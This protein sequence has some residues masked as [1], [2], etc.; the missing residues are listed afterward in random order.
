MESSPQPPRSR[1]HS[2]R[3]PRS[4]R[5]ARGAMCRWATPQD[6]HALAH[7]V[8]VCRTCHRWVACVVGVNF[9]EK[10]MGQTQLLA[11]DTSPRQTDITNSPPHAT[12][13]PRHRHEACIRCL[14]NVADFPLLRDACCRVRTRGMPSSQRLHTN[15]HSYQNSPGSLKREARTR[16]LAYGH[17]RGPIGPQSCQM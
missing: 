10:Y 12:R 11:S 6:A 1:S 2:H 5:S 9:S 3:T 7:A 17:T 15:M 14:R 16:G 8:F 4:T 13:R